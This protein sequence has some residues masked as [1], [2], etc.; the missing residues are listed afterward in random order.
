MLLDGSV[1]EKDI[2]VGVAGTAAIAIIL[3]FTSMTYQSR[4]RGLSIS[5]VA[6]GIIA[7]I[8]VAIRFV[9]K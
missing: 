3:G 8:G 7:A 4:G 2:Y 5:G 9:G 6:L 1:W